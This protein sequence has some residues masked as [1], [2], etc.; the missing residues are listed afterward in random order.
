MSSATGVAFVLGAAGAVVLH[1][2]LFGRAKRNI[3]F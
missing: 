1:L 3:G 2:V